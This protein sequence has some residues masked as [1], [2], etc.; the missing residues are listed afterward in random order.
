MLAFSP[1]MRHA[2]RSEELK[3][4]HSLMLEKGIRLHHSL[5]EYTADWRSEES[6]EEDAEQEGLEMQQTEDDKHAS[7]EAADRLRLLPV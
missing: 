5:T 2:F 1:S 4:L 3:R 6:E 7:K